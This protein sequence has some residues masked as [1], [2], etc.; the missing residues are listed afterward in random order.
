MGRAARDDNFVT[1]LMGVDFNNMQTPELIAVDPVNG[2]MLVSALITN[3]TSAPVPI[4]GLALTMRFD[5]LIVTYT[6]ST[7]TVISTVVT[8]L[9]GVTQETLTNT[10][11]AT[12]DDFQRT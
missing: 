4:S 1:T 2:R 3:S 9:A 12:V 6:D 10:V 5:R 7:K 8:K 11:S